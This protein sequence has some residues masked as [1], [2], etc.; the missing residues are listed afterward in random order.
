[1]PITNK[2]LEDK[3]QIK[4]KSNIKVW[5]VNNGRNIKTLIHTMREAAVICINANIA[6]DGKNT[7]ITSIF[8]KLEN[9]VKKI[10]YFKIFVLFIT[11]PK[12]KDKQY[13]KKEILINK[14]N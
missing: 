4:T 7:I 8:I 5:I 9:V 10:A 14:I 6:M 13:K 3:Y 12:T 2:I 1:M 11:I